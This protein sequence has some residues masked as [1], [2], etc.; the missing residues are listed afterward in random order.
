MLIYLQKFTNQVKL[1]LLLWLMH[2][3][4]NYK[5]RFVYLCV[6][7][8]AWGAMALS[9]VIATLGYDIHYHNF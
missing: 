9:K 7:V 2:V 3:G 4:G 6:E 1:M 5:L 8:V